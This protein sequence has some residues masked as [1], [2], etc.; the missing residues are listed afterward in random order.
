MRIQKQCPS[1]TVSTP[2]HFL[3]WNQKAI[4][5]KSPTKHCCNILLTWCIYHQSNDQMYSKPEECKT[6]STCN[7]NVNGTILHIGQTI[8][9]LT[10]HMWT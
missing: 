10:G 4:L 3:P 1:F 5:I 8:L 6:D 2:W 9:A 7:I